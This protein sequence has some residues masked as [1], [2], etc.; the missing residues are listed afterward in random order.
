MANRPLEFAP[1]KHFADRL[2]E[3]IASKNS[4]LCVGI[5]PRP[6]KFP[7]DFRHRIGGDIEAATKAVLDFNIAVIELVRPHAV[8][9]KV[10]SAFFERLGPYG[11]PAFFATLYAA[12]QMGLLAIADVKRG[13]IPETAEAYADAYFGVYGADAM[14]VNPFFGGDGVEPFIKRAAEAGGGI[15]ALV[16]T[17]NASSADFLEAKLAD[18]SPL[19]LYIAAKVRSWG[20]AH[21]GSCGQSLVG[22]VVS[23]R[24]PEEAAQVRAAMPSTPFLVPGFGA[25]GGT[26]GTIKPCFLAGG[27]GAIVNSSRGIVYAFDDEKYKKT[28]GDAWEA[29]IEAAAKDAKDAINAA[30]L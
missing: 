6:E 2:D 10:Q 8:A 17:T 7:A 14:T 24:H 12:K 16:R 19:Y 22:A 30:A 23:A 29:A 9:I 4:R 11:A 20:E 13:D 18:G 3:A 21:K 27:R 26:G 25:Q 1:V 28:H 15:F 5:D